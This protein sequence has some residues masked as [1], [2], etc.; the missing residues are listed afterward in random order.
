MFRLRFLSCLPLYITVLFQSGASADVVDRSLEVSK[1]HRIFKQQW[2]VTMRQSPVFASRLGDRRFNQQWRDLSKSARMER[3]LTSLMALDDIHSVDRELLEGV[4]RV[5]YDLFEQRILNQ[6][7]ARQF[8]SIL[9]PIS[10]RGGIQSLD[11]TGNRLRMTTVLD[12]DDW[13]VRLS[14]IDILMDQTIALMKE[15]MEKG[16]VPPKITMQRVP[17]QIEKQ[18]VK[19]PQESL[20]YKPFA[21]MPKSFSKDDAERIKLKAEQ[22]IRDKVMPA[23]QKLYDFFTMIYLPACRDSIGAS[24][25]PNGRAFYEFRVKYYT[26]TDLTP[27]EIHKIGLAEV[28]RLR[29]EMAEVMSEV[30]FDGTLKEFFHFLRTD[31]RFYYDSPEELFDAYLA[32]AKRIDPKLISLFG[33]LPRMPYGLKRIPEAI[34]PDTT[35]AY[36]SRPA[37]DGSRAGYYYVNLYKPETRPKYEM[38]VLTVHESVPG[39][40]LQIALQQELEQLPN[41]RRYAGFTVFTEG[42]GLY[43]EQLGYDLDLY[44]DPY[45]KFGQLTYDMWRAVRLV[46][47]TGMHYKGWTRQRAIDY[48]MDNAARQELDIVNEIDRYISWPGQALA[49]KLGQLK[50]MSLRAKAKAALAE[51]FDIREFHDTVLGQGAVPLSVLEDIVTQWIEA[52][53]SDQQLDNLL[54]D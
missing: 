19:D 44:K 30:K 41:F 37:A 13:L 7:E 22:V 42:W 2:E 16:I 51:K 31:S 6:L 46:V 4:E 32:I 47:D 36:Y 53:Q 52:K 25:L 35:T 8:Q 17:A 48:F 54:V 27:D 26:T 40:H 5:N 28:E 50:F 9:I 10:Q 29:G 14:K 38:E 15:G 3:H 49:Y 45:S 20:F 43:S 34:A 24:D 12:Y 18:L 39:H 1:L 23:Y 33:K 21:T 11:E